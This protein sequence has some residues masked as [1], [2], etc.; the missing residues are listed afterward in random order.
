[1]KQDGIEPVGP[2]TDG[3]FADHGADGDVE[4]DPALAEDQSADQ[5][6]TE[7]LVLVR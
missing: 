1:M 5:A 4:N 3:R 2:T 7:R 6:E